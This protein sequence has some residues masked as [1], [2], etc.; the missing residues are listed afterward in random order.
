MAFWYQKS[1]DMVLHEAFELDKCS[2]DA[3]AAAALVASVQVDSNCADCNIPAE[4]NMMVKAGDLTV[5][6]LST[7]VGG[8]IVA[9]PEPPAL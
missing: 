4:G 3:L 2:L 5:N 9:V 6:T 7:L 1:V 8:G